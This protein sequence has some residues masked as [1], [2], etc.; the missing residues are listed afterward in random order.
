MQLDNIE[1]NDSQCN[2][3]DACV[4]DIVETKSIGTF[5]IE[6]KGGIQEDEQYFYF[7][8]IA[9]AY[10]NVDLNKDIIQEGAFAKSIASKQEFPVLVE[11]KMSDA[12]GVVLS[13]YE[14]RGGLGCQIRLSKELSQGKEMAIKIR[15]KIIQKMSIGYIVKQARYDQK[16]RIRI[17][18][19]AQLLEISLVAVPMNM[20][21]KI[22]F[23]SLEGKDIDNIR[24]L[25]K[26]LKDLGLGSTEAKS[27]IS[28]VKGVVKQDWE[29][30]RDALQTKSYN[31]G[32]NQAK[33]DAERDYFIK[34]ISNNIQTIKNN[35]KK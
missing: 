19:E 4:D 11:H 32:Y 24:T 35:L 8:G 5:D 27:L 18:T 31:E 12:I 13:L 16:N 15:D 34:S 3:F 21:T 6:Y 25:E 7:E 14:V 20:N 10:G 30:G 22:F 33:R 26:E 1:Q 2:N 9:A 17:I 28:L 23:K 29:A